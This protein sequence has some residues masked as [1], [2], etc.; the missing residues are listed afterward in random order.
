[1]I[2][3]GLLRACSPLV[4]AVELLDE[5]LGQQSL[6]VAH[7]DDV[8]LAMEVDSTVVTVTGVM[9]L[10]LT[11]RCAVENLVQCLLVDIP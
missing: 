10:R 1:M 3:I 11:G 6:E 2:T 5:P 4:R 9:A 7:E 8:I